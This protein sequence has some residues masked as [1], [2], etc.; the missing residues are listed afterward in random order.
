MRRFNLYLGISLIAL[1]MVAAIISFFWTPFDPNKMDFGSQFASPNSEHAL[2]TD[3]FGRDL[4]SRLMI[5]ARST[6]Y[7]GFIAVGIAASI[8]SL[9][10]ALAGYFG[11]LFDDISMR[12]IDTLYAFPAILM[13]L[14]LAAIFKPGTLTAMTAIGIATIPIFARL[15]R[16]SVL[17]QKN[18]PY[19]EA[20]R[21]QGMEELSILFKHILPNSL[22]PIIVQASLSLAV[23]VLAE[24]ALS[25]LGL[26][27]PPN[28]PSWGNM[29]REAQGFLSFSPYP[30][31][32]PGLAIIV[33]VLGW[34]LLGD[35]LRDF[36]DPRNEQ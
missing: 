11:N 23:A 10:G 19:V 8:G 17:T 4:L 32:V 16:S 12:L 3:N 25:F 2:G 26:G 34:S 14:L 6:L 35:G 1:V 29:L 36:L 24:A 9:I 27:S 18:L 21:A 28:V 31:L 7:V 13:A 20:A 30:A 33:T 5:G 15:M 22:S